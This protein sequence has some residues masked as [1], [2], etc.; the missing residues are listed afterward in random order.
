MESGKLK[1]DAL[2]I[3]I[4]GYMGAGKSTFAR[5]M[6]E[7]HRNFALVD[8]DAE[9]KQVMQNDPAIRRGLARTFG[10]SVIRGQAIDFRTLGAIVFSNSENVLSL[11]AL[12]HPLVLERLKKL[13]VVN[14]RSSRII[15]DAA[16]IPLWNIEAWFDMVIW[17]RASFDLRL[18]RLLKKGL[19]SREDLI[20]RMQRQQSL[21]SEPQG[22]PWKFIENNKTMPEL[23]KQSL[24][25][26]AL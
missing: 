4:A 6:T 8:A 14:N 26:G 1:S 18:E 2:R 16:L 9:A 13:I 10:P 24:N 12:V 17:V 5:L 3:G 15:C 23:Q 20:A 7:S 22:E 19:H 21:F 11:N 25:F